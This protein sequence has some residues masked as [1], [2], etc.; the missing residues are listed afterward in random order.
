MTNTVTVNNEVNET[1]ETKKLSREK[2]FW[3]FVGIFVAAGFLL[4]V[5]F[6]KFVPSSGVKLL[7][8]ADIVF[9]FGIG[10]LIGYFVFLR[11]A[12]KQRKAAL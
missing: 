1:N 12:R 2:K 5:I 4:N 11:K 3:I 6:S 10:A 9:D 8:P 7:N